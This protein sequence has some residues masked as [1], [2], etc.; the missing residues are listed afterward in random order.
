MLTD[1]DLDAVI[2]ATPAS[3]HFEF[4]AAALEVGKHVMVEK[5][6]AQT[7]E[8]C[9]QLI[10]RA[11]ESQLVLMAGH[12]FVYN[13]AV[14]K[15][16]EYLDSGLL[17]EVYYIYSQRLNLGI[18]RRDVNALW[19]FAPHDISII[20]YWLGD[21]PAAVVARGYSYIQPDVEDVVFATLDYPSGVG[22]NVHVSW[23]DP[24]KVRRMTVVGSEKMVVYDDVS[25]D[26]RVVVYDKGVKKGSAEPVSLG[27]FADY[28]EFQL[29]LRAGDILIPK[30]D[31]VEP[32]KVECE[33]FVEC[34]LTGE[35]AFTDG[36]TGLEVVSVL[37][38]AQES[39]ARNGERVGV[40]SPPT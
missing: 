36:R 34:V 17:G 8:Q 23:L 37:E 2:I 5:P 33:H 40:T 18:L 25:Q 1:P 38:A 35:R 15:V 29:L 16:K 30:I 12:V 26:S 7:S 4:A 39:L 21:S 3:T 27:A 19:N 31:F 20:N 24:R 10:E 22:A 32:L 6:L 11:E 14:R 28:A 13:A 9:R